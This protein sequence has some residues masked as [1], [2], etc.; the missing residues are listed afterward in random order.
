MSSPKSN[1]NQNKLATATPAPKVTSGRLRNSVKDHV[2][3]DPSRKATIIK[4]EK[5]RNQQNRRAK[6][7][8]RP[9]K[10][11]E[12]FPEIDDACVLDKSEEKVAKLEKYLKMATKRSKKENTKEVSQ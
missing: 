12:E 8:G 5:K 6:P 1:D 11:Y 3:G 10:K 4:R 2:V 9:A 7:R